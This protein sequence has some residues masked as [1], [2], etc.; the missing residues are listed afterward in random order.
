[1]SAVV[2]QRVL[3]A[4]LR[5]DH[6]GLWSN[7]HAEDGWWVTKVPGGALRIPVRPDGYQH[8]VRTAEARVEADGRVVDELAGLLDVLA[9]QDDPEAE[10]GWAVFR[11]EVGA[12]VLARRLADEARPRVLAVKKQ[13]GMA[14]A[15]AD[16]AIAAHDDH[17]VH[18]ASRA[19]HG[20]TEAELLAYA[21]E[22]APVFAVQWLRSADLQ[23][24]GELPGWW[25]APDML[26]AHP[27]TAAR[28]GLPTVD[29]PGILVHPTLSMRTVA[30]ASDPYTHVKLPLATA[31]L[32]ARNKRTIAP[33]TLVDGAV[34]QNLLEKLAAAEP[35]FAGRILHADETTW[36]HAGDDTHAFLIRRY[37]RELEGSVVVPAA[38]L[39][40]LADRLGDPRAVMESYLDL[41]I[42]WHVHLWLRHGIALEAHQQNIHLVLDPDGGLRLLYKDNDGARFD[43]RHAL[44]VDDARMAVADE[45]ELADVFTTITLHL[46]AAG[47][48]LSLAGHGHDVPSPG[49]ALAGRIRAASDRWGG[50]ELLSTRV[51]EAETLPVK[52]MLTA[53]TLLPKQRIGCTDINK[54]YLRTGPNYLRAAQ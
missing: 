47:P 31:T 21:P 14:G 40:L 16:E 43:A 34:M 33:G 19:K 37:P 22:H 51:L 32:G 10:A 20:L 50:S 38:G 6:L 36:G 15:V 45:G 41:L 35:A 39:G 9:P 4:L 30:L 53:G 1:M 44:A 17:P 46:A 2:F 23:V 5:E 29:G 12:E 48:L 28:L 25:P 18:P 7:G 42:D 8:A 26:P 3:D 27:L 52:A 11:A 24:T 49:E 13:K 54:Y